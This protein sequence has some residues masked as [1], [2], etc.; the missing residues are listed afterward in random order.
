MHIAAIFPV[1]SRSK[2]IVATAKAFVSCSASLI[3]SLIVVFSGEKSCQEVLLLFC[4]NLMI[5]SSDI[6]TLLVL[7]LMVVLVVLTERFFLAERFFSFSSDALHSLRASNSVTSC[8]VGVLGF[9]PLGGVERNSDGLFFTMVDN[10]N[11]G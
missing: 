4:S 9:Q 1:A 3:A 11:G 5:S 2:L 7:L 10:D 6:N 8:V